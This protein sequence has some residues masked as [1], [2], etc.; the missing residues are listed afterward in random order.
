MAFIPNG[1][2]SCSWVGYTRRALSSHAWCCWAGGAAGAAAAVRAPLPPPAA[3]RAAPRHSAV[4]RQRHREGQ[5]QLAEQTQRKKYVSAFLTLFIKGF[6]DN[7]ELSFL[8]RQ[9]QSSDNASH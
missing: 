3:R 7:M 8:E 2:K 6:I 1:I 9:G 5:P 4:V